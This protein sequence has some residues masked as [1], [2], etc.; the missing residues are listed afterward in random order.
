M[1][2]STVLHRSPGDKGCEENQTKHR[3]EG[4][5]QSRTILVVSPDCNNLEKNN[6][7]VLAERR[8]EP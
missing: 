5:R 3:E 8:L 7:L 1:T 6:S 4:S 2:L